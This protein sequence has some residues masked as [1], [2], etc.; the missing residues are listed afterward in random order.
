MCGGIA[1]FSPF[2]TYNVR[3]VD[4]VGIVGI[5]G[6]GHLAIK[7]ARAWGCHVTAFTSNESKSDELRE[8]GAHEVISTTDANPKKLSGL[9]DFLIVTSG[10]P[11]DLSR[12]M[13]FLG[14]KGR[15]HFAGI[16]TAPVCF[17]VR[18]D[19]IAWQRSISGISNG[20]PSALNALVEFAARHR[21]A[22]KIERFPMRQVNEAIAH[23][24]SGRARYRVVLDSDF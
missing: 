10:A 23:M 17:T 14:P 3:P 16:T 4:R 24:R 5:G 12:L 8:F 11:V 21:I 22:P 9:L 7:I 18:P 13:S 19:L 15:L 2:L 20:T 1:V 6:L